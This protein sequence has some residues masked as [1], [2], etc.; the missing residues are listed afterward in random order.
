M[1]FEKKV[2]VSASFFI[3]EDK[4]TEKKQ[5]INLHLSVY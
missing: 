4:I 1:G 3:S 2:K 5:K